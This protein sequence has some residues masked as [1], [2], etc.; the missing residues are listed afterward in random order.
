MEQ[1]AIPYKPGKAMIIY[2]AIAGLVVWFG[3]VLQFSL[4][5]PAQIKTGFSLTG[6]IVQ[7]LSF[8]TIQCNLMVG[9]SLWALLLKPSNSLHK[10]FSRGYVLGGICLYIIVVGLVYNIILRSLWQPEGLFKIADELLHS[11]NPLLFAIFWLIFV[12]RRDKLKWAQSL[13][14]LWF[15]FL[16]LVYS[17][18]RG[19]ITHF[20]PYPFIDVNKLGYSHVFINSFVLLIV[21]LVL[22]LLLITVTRSLKREA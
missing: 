8:F 12:A 7:I 6:A 4:S 10:F 17:L 22:G 18:I 3:L 9:L 13:N 21:F 11:I 15:P 2:A 16:Y 20:Y 14:W 1:S 19:P 5:I